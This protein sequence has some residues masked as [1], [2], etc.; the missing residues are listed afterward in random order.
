MQEKLATKNFKRHKIVS[1]VMSVNTLSTQI[2]LEEEEIT[3]IIQVIQ[4]S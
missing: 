4:S 3:T 2:L 1:E